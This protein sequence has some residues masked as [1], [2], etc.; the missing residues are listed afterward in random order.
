MHEVVGDLGLYFDPKN[1]TELAARIRTIAED[2]TF[3]NELTTKIRQNRPAL[4][5]WQDVAR[6]ILHAADT[7]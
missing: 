4:R 2:P 6:D 5:S 1:A 7:Y 3:R